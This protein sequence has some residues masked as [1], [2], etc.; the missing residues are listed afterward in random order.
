MDMCKE[1]RQEILAKVIDEEG[2]YNFVP[3]R[4]LLGT[5]L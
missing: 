4:I 2:S 1:M 3:T 5:S